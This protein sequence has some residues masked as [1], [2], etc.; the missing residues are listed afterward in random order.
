MELTCLWSAIAW[1]LV[2]VDVRDVV[3]NR[4]KASGHASFEIVE[5]VTMRVPKLVISSMIS[6]LRTF[7]AGRSRIGRNRNSQQSGR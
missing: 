4:A 5:L 6:R 7:A 1:S 2:P 3:G